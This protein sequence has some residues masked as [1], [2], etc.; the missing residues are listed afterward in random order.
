M[1]LLG[2]D[3]GTS[4]IKALLY[5]AATGRTVASSERPTPTSSPQPGWADFPAEAVWQAAAGAVH[6][7]VTA[8]P[9]L[10]GVRAVAVSSLAESGV[11]LDG[12]GRPL[13]PFMAWFDPRSKP[14]A[15]R[16]AERLGLERIYRVSGQRMQYTLGV[17]KWLWWR[18]AEPE[19]AAAARHWLSMGDWMIYRLSGEL[20]TDYTLAA[21][22]GLFDQRS[23]AWSAELLAAAEVPPGLLPRAVPSGTPVGRVRAAAAQ[24]T[25]L[26]QGTVVVTGGHD[27][28]CAALAAGAVAPGAAVD[29]T[30]TATSIVVPVDRYLGDSIPWESGFSCYAHTAPGLYIVRAGNKATGGAIAW[31]VRTLWGGEPDEAAYATLLAEAA[32]AEGSRAGLFWSPAFLGAGTPDGDYGAHAALVGLTPQH[33]RGD[34][35]RAL[36]EAL[37]FWLRRN[38][39][40]L[41]A[42]TGRPLSRVHLVGGSTR[43]EL[44]S[45][46]KATISGRPIR[47]PEIVES[48]ALGAALLAGIGTGAFSSAAAALASLQVGER[49]YQ[50]DPAEQAQYRR[51]YEQVYLALYPALAPLEERLQGLA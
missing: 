2:L 36:L 14:Q 15:E 42:L 50:P 17:N 31:L 44:L 45:R 9:G 38:L 16:W 18:D 10:A 41:E 26:P 1:R 5:D 40:T 30:G 46:L 11:P 23:R 19:R 29:S 13:A 22:T 39:D 35:V 33:T 25:G 12:S 20:A 7:L 43:L 37:A 48:S 6:E 47:V 8:G 49:V 21:R 32:A 24:T 34:I 3:I 27:H 28:L 4:R 51:L